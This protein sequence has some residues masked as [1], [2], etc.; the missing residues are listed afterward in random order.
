VAWVLGRRL[1]E[2][3]RVG[4]GGAGIGKALGQGQAFLAVAVFR[5]FLER[6]QLAGLG[7][8]LEG[9][10][11]AFGEAQRDRQLGTSRFAFESLH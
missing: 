9:R 5:R 4:P 3:G 7:L 10:K 8:N 6:N 11:I 1:R 2:H